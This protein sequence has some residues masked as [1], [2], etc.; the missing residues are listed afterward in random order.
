MLLPTLP[1]PLH[2]EPYNPFLAMDQLDIKLWDLMP[3]PKGLGLSRTM[4]FNP[5]RV[6]LVMEHP[7]RGTRRYAGF[8]TYFATSPSDPFLLGWF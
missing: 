1:L 4:P 6:L 5:E 7:G 3:L 2:L 8:R